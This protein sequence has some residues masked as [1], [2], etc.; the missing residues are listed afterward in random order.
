MV[1]SML[2]GKKVF[3]KEKLILGPGRTKQIFVSF[4]FWRS[5]FLADIFEL[6]IFSLGRTTEICSSKTSLIDSNI[7]HNPLG[8]MTLLLL[9]HQEKQNIF[10]Q[11]NGHIG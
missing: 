11:E 10:A 4:N 9:L 2:K 3:A 7:S 5:N 6:P 8:K 1:K